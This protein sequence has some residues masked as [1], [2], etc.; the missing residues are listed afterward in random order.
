MGLHGC[1]LDR[2]NFSSSW[3]KQQENLTAHQICVRFSLFQNLTTTIKDRSSTGR[4]LDRTLMPNPQLGRG[5]VGGNWPQNAPK[6]K[7]QF[8][9][10]WVSWK[11]VGL[12]LK[13]IL[14]PKNA[15]DKEGSNIW[16]MQGLH[17]EHH[18]WLVSKIHCCF[19]KAIFSDQ[20]LAVK[21]PN[22]FLIDQ[23]RMF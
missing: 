18:H 6:I 7:R 3:K 11:A 8:F 22:H 12:A 15:K 21:F 19:Y 1:I 17:F 20:G 23:G 5:L 16:A 4:M 10:E 14:F 13:L 2:C 9:S